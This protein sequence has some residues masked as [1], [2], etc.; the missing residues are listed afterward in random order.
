MWFGSLRHAEAENEYV[1][2]IGDEFV[3]D[4]ADN[5]RSSHSGTGASWGYIPGENVCGN[6]HGYVLA[7]FQSRVLSAEGPHD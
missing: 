5:G 7:H 3:G 1:V 6:A 2:A 4:V